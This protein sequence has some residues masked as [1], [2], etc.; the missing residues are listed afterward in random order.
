MLF[1]LSCIKSFFTLIKAQSRGWWT[2]PQNCEAAVSR[3]TKNTW[4][5][6]HWSVVFVR[7]RVPT[8][9]TSCV[10]NSIRMRVAASS[11][12]RSAATIP[13]STHWGVRRVNCVNF[14]SQEILH[15]R[16]IWFALKLCE[17]KNRKFFIPW[18]WAKNIVDF[19]DIT[20]KSSQMLSV[21][22]KCAVTSR[23]TNRKLVLKFS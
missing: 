5:P 13:D 7:L 23:A 3:I 9:F 22:L 21:A 15:R 1:I 14:K 4:P 6:G 10:P 17:L 11:D 8:S 2:H 18:L 12:K 20:A 16:K 19:S